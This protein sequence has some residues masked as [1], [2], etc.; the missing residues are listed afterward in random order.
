MYPYC[1]HYQV[2]D[3]FC[4]E[5]LYV[6]HPI[7][8][9]G[10]YDRIC[11]DKGYYHL[12]IGWIHYFDDQ[13]FADLFP[14]YVCYPRI[15]CFWNMD[16]KKIY[17]VQ[18]NKTTRDAHQFLNRTLN[19]LTHHLYIFYDTSPSRSTHMDSLLGIGIYDLS[20]EKRYASIQSYHRRNS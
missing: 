3:I 20:Y 14:W 4:E 8:V 11:H 13:Y 9:D 1:I 16:F 2:K 7:D 17:Q 6:Y 18:R 10:I 5:V 19:I 15:D 12:M